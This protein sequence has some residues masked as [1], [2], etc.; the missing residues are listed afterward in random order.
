MSGMTDRG[1][2]LMNKKA[3]KN[4]S[5][6]RSVFMRDIKSFSLRPYPALQACGV[7]RPEGV[8]GFTLIELLVVV[9]IIGILAAIALPKY[10][11]AVKR[12]HVAKILPV[13]RSVYDAERV[14]RMEKNYSDNVE[15]L[16]IEI[17]AVSL[18]GYTLNNSEFFSCNKGSTACA[19]GISNQMAY[20]LQFRK[21]NTD[22]INAQ[23]WFG[24]CAKGNGEPVFL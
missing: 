16:S 24:V 19:F 3:F 21:I 8:R 10:E 5:S 7:T 22:N 15:D 14:L 11:K 13:L 12:S 20:I 23:L 2:N 9:L 6:S 1:E 18:P 17:P 4:S